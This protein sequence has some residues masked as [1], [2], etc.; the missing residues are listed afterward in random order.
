MH[1]KIHS[2][3]GELTALPRP[4]S[5]IHGARIKP[6]WKVVGKERERGSGG[7]TEGKRKGGE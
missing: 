3:A 1:K 7:N 2:D 4:H 5:W 6:P